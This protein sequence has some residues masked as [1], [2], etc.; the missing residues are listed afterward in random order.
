MIASV[1]MMLDRWKC[2]DKEIEV[3]NEFKIL[4]S[5]IISRTAFGSSYAEGQHIFHMLMQLAV[6]ISKN[7]YRITI[8]GIRYLELIEICCNQQVLAHLV[9]I[10]TV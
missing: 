8:P 2:Q 3:Y 1:E 6:I 7:K 5:E 4:T 9:M 10:F